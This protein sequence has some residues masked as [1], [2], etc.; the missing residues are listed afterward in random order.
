MEKMPLPV[1]CI[2]NIILGGS[3]KTPV[4][5]SLQKILKSM[6]FSVHIVSK[7]YG[8]KLKG[9]SKVLQSNNAFEVGDEPLLLSRTGP[10]WVSKERAPGIKKA[11]ENG[12][13]IVLLD[14]GHQ[15]NSIEKD[16]SLLV[17]DSTIS[18]GNGNVIPSGPLREP[19]SSGLSR[20]D[21]IVLVGKGNERVREEINCLNMGNIPIFEAEIKPI[22]KKQVWKNK[23]LVAFSG[24]AH[25]G[26][27]FNT[28]ENLD[29][30]I[31]GK[32]FFPDHYV[33]TDKDLKKLKK[34]AH[35]ERAA[36]I[37]TEKDIVRIPPEQGQEI[38]VL[39][40][41]LIFSDEKGI[42][43]AITDIL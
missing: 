24:I 37:T 9:P 18:F 5:Q 12:A 39:P 23:K 22:K 11:W 6:G 36:L 3:G 14:D 21:A 25:P 17:I 43:T 19:M 35:L 41:E 1:I 34:V 7:G 40:V 8:G 33:Y 30:D 10:V 15:D 29:C 42:K 20:A 4:T 2:G 38:I 16:F 32:F 28:L 13:D 31:R 26:K 27:F